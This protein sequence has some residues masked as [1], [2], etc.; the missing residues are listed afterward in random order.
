M[1]TKTKTTIATIAT[2]K[3]SKSSSSTD[4]ISMHRF[5]LVLG[6]G[7]TLST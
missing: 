6:C 1:M 2:K 3:A 5:G 7:Q 4:G